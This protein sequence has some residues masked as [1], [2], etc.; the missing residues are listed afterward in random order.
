MMDG[1]GTKG[2][3]D[4]G[5]NWTEIFYKPKGEQEENKWC[6]RVEHRTGKKSNA[7]CPHVETSEPNGERAQGSHVTAG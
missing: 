6:R 5:V 1:G 7:Y 4:L 2:P 3:T